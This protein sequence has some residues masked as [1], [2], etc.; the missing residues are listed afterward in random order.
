MFSLSKSPL[1]MNTN[2]LAHLY[3]ENERKRKRRR[4]CWTVNRGG[5]ATNQ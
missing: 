5:G 3:L 4:E 1:D 2:Y